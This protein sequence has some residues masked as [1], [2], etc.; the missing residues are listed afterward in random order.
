M[1]AFRSMYTAMQSAR[2]PVVVAA[3][4]T[5]QTLAWASSYYLPAILA[6]DMASAVG[7]SRAWV[8][9]AFSASLLIT[10]VLGPAVGRMIDRRGGAAIL[11]AS[12]IVFAIGLVT[13]SMS[14]GV[15]ILLAAWAL[16]G[17]GMALGLYDAAFATLAGL[18][19]R[20]AR[21]PITGITLFAGFASTVG[22]PLSAFLD[23]K[24]GWRGTCVAWAAMHVLI[25]LPLNLLLI[26]RARFHAEPKQEIAASWKP[27]KPMVLL[28]Y[29]FAASWFVTGAMAAHLPTLLERMGASATQAIAASALVGPAQVAARLVEFTIMRNA[30]PLVS[31][32]IA[33]LMH[34]LGAVILATIGSP[35]AAL[36]ALLHGAGNGLLT[37]ARGTVPLALFGPEGYGARTGLL[38]AP[39]RA[40][41]AAA[42]F[43]FGLLLDEMGRGVLWVSGGLCLSA[44]AALL[45]LKTTV[46][47]APIYPVTADVEPT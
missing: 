21:G 27:Y 12:N 22:W 32:R 41:Q 19:G 29:I 36:F 23:A 37:I 4:G 9:G 7:V 25:G 11:V 10:A 13:L 20:E 34:P 30:H 24:F 17:I 2:R 39:A 16:L 26:P 15:A 31:A 6:D 35:A 38:G 46:K 47:Y 45:L 14:N 18:Y 42:P 8:F 43:L 33:A 1:T 5:T 3:L 44:L 40:A 28:A